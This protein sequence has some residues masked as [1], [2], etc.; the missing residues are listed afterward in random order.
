MAV[1]FPML[2]DTALCKSEDY[3]WSFMD[4]GVSAIMFAAGFSSSLICTHT[5]KKRKG[6]IEE[7]FNVITGNI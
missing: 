6:V 2:F 5:N 7:L 3:G 4:V 1:D